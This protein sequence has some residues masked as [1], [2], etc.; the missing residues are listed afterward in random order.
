M[1]LYHGTNID[2]KTIELEK[3]FPFKDFGKGFYL[4]DIQDQ[5]EALAQKKS[6]LFG[7]SPLV[8]EYAFSLEE[9][10]NTGLKIH[11]FHTPSREWAKF[12]FNNRNRNSNFHHDYDI[13]YGPIANDGVAY[14]LSRYEE[15]T[16][17]LDELAKELE[18]NNLNNQYYFGTQ[19]AIDLLIRL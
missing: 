13:V 19:Q 1:I 18:F 11:Y 8:Q 14:L 10:K 4:T 9:A 2:F 12:I 16:I 17:N 3:C 6:K 7:G 5:A 15:G